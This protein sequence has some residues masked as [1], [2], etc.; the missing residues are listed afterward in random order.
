MKVYR[1]QKAN[2]IGAY[3]NG[4]AF[5]WGGNHHNPDTG[6]PDPLEDGVKLIDSSYRCGFTSLKKLKEWFT[7][8]ERINMKAVGIEVV[9]LEVPEH[10]IYEGN[11]QCMFKWR[12]E[13]ARE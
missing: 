8:D 10:E 9:V 1:M 6:H 11:K 4:N 3:Q 5:D 2:G 12:P 7:L 13:Y